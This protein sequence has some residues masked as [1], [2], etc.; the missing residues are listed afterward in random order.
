[1]SKPD[2]ALVAALARLDALET[3]Q[4]TTA[5]AAT[6]Y[7]FNSGDTAWI[8]TAT[9]L[10][11]LMTIPGLALFYAGLSTAG[12][13]LSAAMQ[14]FAVTCWVTVLWLMLGYSLAFGSGVW[15]IGGGEKFWFRGDSVNGKD[16]TPVEGVYP[17]VGTVP[18]PVFCMFQLT[19]AIITSAIITGASAERM[20]FATLLIFTFFWH[21]LVY[22]PI[23]HWVWGGGF[24]HTM[25]GSQGVLDY[26]GG[27]V[28]HI[29]SGVSG[30]V[31]TL[32]LG[33]RRGF[34]L[35]A[36]LPP[37]NALLT[38]IG[39]SFLWVGWFGFN[40]GSALSAGGSASMALLT[41]QL[42]AAA[43]G[44]GWM[45]VEYLDKGKPTVLGIVSGSISGLVGITPACGF[46]D[47]TGGFV[48]GVITGISCYFGIQFKKVLG[49]DDAL[50]AFGIHGIGG[51]IGGML[52]GLFANPK[53]AGCGAFYGCGD[54][55][56]WQIAGILT[57]SSYSAVVTAIIMMGLKYTIGIRV[58]ADDEDMGLDA[59]E[60]GWEG[61][62]SQIDSKKSPTFSPARSRFESQNGEG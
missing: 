18:E 21:L 10:V 34:S 55:L 4:N 23:C 45:T 17:L 51:M 52:T 42:A 12:N 47:Q 46:V 62:A 38:F 33:P 16:L 31:V 7:P 29:S 48:I 32:I 9:C 61:G 58:S 3:W 59:S 30:L 14:S 54:Q 53:I 35:G 27:D 25:Y 11:L 39:A 37:H 1:M 41:T 40:A 28:V 6:D 13:A 24:M 26:A 57:V 49:A 56:G 8:L 50:D 2:A 43:G 5:K 60:H 44:M 19:F 22:C 15:F 20:K 36:E